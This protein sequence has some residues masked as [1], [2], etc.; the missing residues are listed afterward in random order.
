[1]GKSRRGGISNLPT[2]GEDTTGM[3]FESDAERLNLPPSNNKTYVEVDGHSYDIPFGTVNDLNNRLMSW[4]LPVIRRNRL[5]GEPMIRGGRPSFALLHQL[6]DNDGWFQ[7]IFPNFSQFEKYYTNNI[8]MVV[9]NRIN[10]AITRM[11]QNGEN[12][13]NL[14]NE[15]V[16]ELA[17]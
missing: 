7:E 15:F 14:H 1:M 2:M 9:N 12:V 6:Y 11:E 13:I 16:D 17:L 4:T 5:T 8:E 3:T 10:Q